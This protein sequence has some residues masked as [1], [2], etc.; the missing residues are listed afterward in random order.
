VK[1]PNISYEC[2]VDVVENDLEA[3]SIFAEAVATFL[4]L[5][6]VCWFICLWTKTDCS[7]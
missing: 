7:G 4:L 2:N 3:I 1:V 5:P 6:G